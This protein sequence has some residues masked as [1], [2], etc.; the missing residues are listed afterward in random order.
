MAAAAGNIPALGLT[1]A[2][3]QIQKHYCQTFLMY[4]GINGTF[5]RRD[6]A[7]NHFYAIA[8]HPPQFPKSLVELFVETMPFSCDESSDY[9]AGE[10]VV[11]PD[12]AGNSES[13]APFM[14]F[15]ALLLAPNGHLNEFTHYK[16]L[17]GALPGSISLDE[18]ALIMCDE[19]LD[20]SGD[21]PEG[22]D[23]LQLSSDYINTMGL[24][25]VP[26]FRR[27]GKDDAVYCFPL[28]CAVPIT[29]ITVLETNG[30]D[31]LSYVT[32]PHEY[33]EQDLVGE[34][35]ASSVT[36]CSYKM[37]S[38]AEDHPFCAR[39]Q[40]DETILSAFRAAI[41]IHGV[42]YQYHVFESVDINEEGG[43][44]EDQDEDE[45]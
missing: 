18:L 3:F 1:E 24:I 35:M 5:I 32:V 37:H 38:F 15:L 10:L 20:E 4:H 11:R 2:N 23:M 6:D 16:A 22:S 14:L 30:N 19:D 39:F 28:C 43:K 17:F 31:A 9:R 29:A 36:N 41:A 7:V 25:D 40:S 27:Y 26:Q 34:A 44:G 42:V 12:P 33:V 8:T 45:D 21:G 13:Y